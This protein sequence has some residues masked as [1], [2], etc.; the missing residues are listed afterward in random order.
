MQSLSVGVGVGVGH[1]DVGI[2]QNFRGLKQEFEIQII[3][4]FER[5]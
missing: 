3:F 1:D 2:Q 4:E 5:N